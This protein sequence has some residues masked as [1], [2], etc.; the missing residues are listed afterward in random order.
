MTED[1]LDHFEYYRRAKS[2]EKTGHF[3]DALSAYAKAIQV[4]E[5]YAHAWFYKAKLHYQLGQ[6]KECVE[7]TERALKLA[8]DWSDHCNKMLRDAKSKI[9]S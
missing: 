2:F 3:D 7:C 5:D 4:N 9:S 6:Y 1:N 8:P